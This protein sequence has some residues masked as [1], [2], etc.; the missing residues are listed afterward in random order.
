MCVV[1]QFDQLT[2]LKLG[3]CY[4]ALRGLAGTLE[5]DEDG[6]EPL[7]REP[8][9]PLPGAGDPCPA[10]GLPLACVRISAAALKAL[11]W[12]VSPAG[13]AVVPSGYPP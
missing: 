13:L 8:E 3:E 2:R 4:G 5:E 10:C 12:V 11:V 9:A 6:G 7:D 1:A